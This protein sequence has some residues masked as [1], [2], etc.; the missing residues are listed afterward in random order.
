MADVRVGNDGDAASEILSMTFDQEEYEVGDVA[1]VEVP[2]AKGGTLILSVE[3]GSGQLKDRVV[4]TTAGSTKVEVPLSAGMA[5]HCYFHAMVIQSHG[6][7]GNDRPIRM[8]GI[9]PVKVSDPSSLLE[10]TLSLPEEIEPNSTLSI[11]VEEAKGMGMEY[12]L[13]VVDEG[14]LG[15]T[16]FQTP[17]PHAFLPGG[18]HWG[19]YVGHVCLGP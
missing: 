16:R 1:V 14:L 4:P 11:E 8:Y 19:S 13:A 6:D 7:S 2:S 17:D 15:L 9:E 10:P 18:Q 12:T 5:P 3:N